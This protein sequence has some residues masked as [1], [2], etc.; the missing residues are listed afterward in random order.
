MK[1][2]WSGDQLAHDGARFM[3]AGRLVSSPDGPDRAAKILEA[4]TSGGFDIAAPEDLGLEA[5]RRVHPDDYL[6]FL[7]TIHDKWTAAFGEDAAVLPNVMAPPGFDR[8][9]QSLVGALGVYTGDLAA[10]IRP[11]TWTTVYAS[12]QCAANAAR[13]TA[14]TGLPAYALCRPPG[15]HASARTAMGFCY[16]NN[17]AIAAEELRRKHARVAIVDFDVH[18]G[19]GTQTIFY[20]RSDVLTASMHSDPSYYYPF[21]SGYEDECGLGDGE[22]ANINACYSADA[23]DAGFLRTFR[24]LAM[25]VEA[26]NPDAVV[27]G[28]GTDSLRSDPHGGHRITPDGIAALAPV[29]RSWNRPTVFVQE[30]GYASDELGPTVARFLAAC[31]GG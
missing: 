10:E 14:A 17:S 15:H 3:K 22:G 5:T 1:V 31:N 6:D 25:A 24:R 30:G 4:L 28:L 29:I 8:V 11:G 12:A 18:H 13:L 9:P 2:F 23:D 20:H 27:V 26:F 7:R 21:H 19:N 16:L